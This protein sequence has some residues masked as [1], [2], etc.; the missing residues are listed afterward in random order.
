MRLD[1]L[2][3]INLFCLLC[4]STTIPRFLEKSNEAVHSLLG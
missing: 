4:K 3:C 1:K 2:I